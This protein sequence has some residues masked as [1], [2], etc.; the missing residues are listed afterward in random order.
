MA[1]QVGG[2]IVYSG[3]E[4]GRVSQKWAANG[5]ISA[6]RVRI[7]Y[8]IICVPNEIPETH[9]L[10]FIEKHISFAFVRERL[11]GSYSDTGR[12]SIDL[13]FCCAFC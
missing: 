8:R 13:S 6:V 9:L 7:G 2:A 4:Y 1:V 5:S 12:P 3:L 11:K 10:R